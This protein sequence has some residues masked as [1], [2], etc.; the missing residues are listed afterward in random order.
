MYSS[1]ALSVPR[2]DASAPLPQSLEGGVTEMRA[3]ASIDNW[4]RFRA[5]QSYVTRALCEIAM[6]EARVRR[7]MVDGERRAVQAGGRGSGDRS[8]RARRRCELRSLQA[9]TTACV[10]RCKR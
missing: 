8:K 10:D 1:T 9:V 2:A 5:E 7:R 4:V 6:R 3:L